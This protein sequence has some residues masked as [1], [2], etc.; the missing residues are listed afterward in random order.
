MTL[1]LDLY[2]S[3][4]GCF[5]YEVHEAGERRARIALCG[6]PTSTMATRAWF[7]VGDRRGGVHYD[8]ACDTCR[9]LLAV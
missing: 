5:H 1:L 4:D 2:Q 9:D 3:A 8:R 6:A 7:R